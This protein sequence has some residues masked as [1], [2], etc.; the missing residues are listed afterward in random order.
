MG[1][2]EN[3]IFTR[4]YARWI[5]EE[6]RRE[7]WE[8]TVK[9]Y[10]NFIFN[11]T[12]GCENIPQKTKAKIEA[13][14]LNKE[15]MPSMR[16]MASAGA[17]CKRDNISAYNCSGVCVN[18]LDVFGECMYILLAGAGLGYSV[19][20]EYINQLPEVNKQKNLPPLRLVV[21]D[22][23]L[24]W[25]QA[26]DFAVK[27]L[28]NGRDVQF[29]LSQ[30]RPAGTPLVTSGGYASGPEPLNRCL[31]FI[32]ETILKA[33]GRKLSS[34]EISDCMNEIGASVVCGGV[35]RSSEIC[36]TDVNDKLMQ[37]SKQ[38][39]T[40]PRRF[41]ANISAT[42]KKQ[43]N[44]LD[45]TQEFVDMARSGSGER[46]IF[47][48]VAA[49]KRSPKRRDTKRIVITNPCAETLLRNRGLCNLSEVVIREK[50]DFDSI[51]DKII[52]ATW[53]GCIQA[54]LTHFPHL[55]PEWKQNAE[56]E[57]LLGVSLTGLCDNIDL[58]T[59]ETLMH[60][61]RT[62]IKT[63]KRA[64][65][66]LGINMPAA[67]TVGK[68]SGTVSALVNS[69]SGL[70]S[71]WAPFFIRRVRISIHDALFRMMVEQ[72]MPYEMD[73]GNHD[74][75][76]FSFPVASPEGCK[77]RD[78]DTAIGQLEWYR[79]LVENWCEM[80]MSCTIYV[81]DSEWLDVC[82]YVYKHF[83]SINGVA[84]FPYDNKKYNQAP[85]EA[86]DEATYLQMVSN[87]PDI[88]F[89]KL[90]N[91]ETQDTTEANRTLACAG[92]AC[93]I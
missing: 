51:Q 17:N 57:R 53:I 52:C 70:H 66:L 12:P 80:N 43:P 72:G 65:G 32:R 68:P 56:E 45:F 84:F 69:S 85:Y 87:M 81:H 62:A 93:E 19:E 37:E 36:L 30:I 11:E 29:D 6:K 38:G 90:S 78:Q 55:R 2:Y 18:S 23:R 49:R 22:T 28:F 48:L 8:E 4:S 89:S 86:I 71:R 64:S 58:I 7:T 50:D 40:H 3:F 77:T 9:R 67:I 63:A 1:L 24:G 5:P 34:L 20:A 76:V 74:T 27:G 82:A 54:T 75:A 88:D 44:V 46:G 25:K 60:W 83:E 31:E 59:P 33:Q 42:Y 10:C 21:P 92:G 14:I 47:N 16:L 13:Y 39:I 91:F 26:V 15:V 79:M 35:R 61:K 73:Q 41:M